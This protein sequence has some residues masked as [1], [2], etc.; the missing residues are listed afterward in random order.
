MVR[1]TLWCCLLSLGL[2]IVRVSAAEEV[3]PAP[4]SNPNVALLLRLQGTDLSANPNLRTLLNRTLEA[5]VGTPDFVELVRAFKLTD[6]D[7]DLMSTALAN[8]AESAGV[9]AIRLLLGRTNVEVIRRTLAGPDAEK[10]IQLL[11]NVGEKSVNELITPIILDA[12]R[13]LPVRET[14]VEAVVKSREGAAWLVKQA[15]ERTLAAELRP[16]A[17]RALA[18]V[19]WPEIVEA[20]AKVLPPEPVKGSSPL[21][22]T[23][24]LIV[25]EGDPV[26]GERV[27]FGSAAA[28]SRCHQVRGKGTDFGPN[29][30]EIGGKYGKDGIYAAILTPSAGIGFGF[31]AWQVDFKNG[32]D[33]FGLIV[34]ETADEIA[35]KA[36][37]GIVSRFKKETIARRTQ[38]STSIM[39]EGLGQAIG[40]DALVNLVEFLATLRKQEE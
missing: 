37:S 13:A 38:Q 25:R 32:D 11:G 28:C 18:E 33:A 27:F 21:P 3:I 40:A 23:E 31:E 5:T 24:E 14:A 9:D 10:A 6:R 29:L 8:S 1:C 7:T 22:P 19:R 35:M 4:P 12:K 34:S 39:P 26:A 16:A 20:A 36:V 2:L 17:T 30:S 15:E